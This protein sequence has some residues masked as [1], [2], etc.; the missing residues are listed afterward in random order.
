MVRGRRASANVRTKSKVASR[1]ANRAARIKINRSL[2]SL[3]KNVHDLMK[4]GGSW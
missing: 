3:K 4:V 2:A 1:A